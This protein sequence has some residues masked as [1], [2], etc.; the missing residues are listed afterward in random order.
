MS[1][2]IIIQTNKREEFID[3]TDLVDSNIDIDEGIVHVF[4]THTTT[5]I[6]INE[7]SDENLP[8]DIIN[9][10]DKLVKKGIWLHDSVDG[11]GDSHIKASLIGSNVTIPITNGKMNL[12]TWQRILFCDFDGPRKRKMILSFIK[13]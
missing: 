5:G 7:N 12:G 8:I 9:F 3:I 11:N 2:E 1:K 6:T 4:T 13:K 10:L